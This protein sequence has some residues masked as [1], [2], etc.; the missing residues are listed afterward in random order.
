MDSQEKYE[1]LLARWG[2]EDRSLETQKRRQK[3]K[4]QLANVASLFKGFIKSA[5]H[6]TVKPSSLQTTH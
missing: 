4:E 5:L 3:Q 2:F 6:M 1:A